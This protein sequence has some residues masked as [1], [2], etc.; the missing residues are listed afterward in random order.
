MRKAAE[1]TIQSGYSHFRFSEAQVSQG[2]QFAGVYSSASANAYGNTFGNGA[3]VNASATGFST[4][5][6]RPTAD[7]GVTVYMFHANEPGAKSAFNAA[8]ILQKYNQ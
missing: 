2:S 3:F 4:P 5:I 7:V 1:L 6:Y 8:E